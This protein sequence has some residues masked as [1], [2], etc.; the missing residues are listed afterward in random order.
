MGIKG[1]GE[2]DWKTM[3]VPPAEYFIKHKDFDFI[4][5]NAKVD[6]HSKWII[7]SLLNKRRV[8]EK[9]GLFGNFSNKMIADAFEQFM[10]KSSAKKLLFN[11]LFDK[12]WL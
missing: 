8:D 1:F 2:K 10:E 4:R 6:P 9:I 5:M 12:W 11:N 7:F 3:E